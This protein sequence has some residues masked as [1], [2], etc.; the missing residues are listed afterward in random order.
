MEDC[1]SITA[2]TSTAKSICVISSFPITFTVT[3]VWF[4]G[5][6]MA[7]VWPWMVP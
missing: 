2:F 3:G 4:R 5:E 7:L 1:F 6:G